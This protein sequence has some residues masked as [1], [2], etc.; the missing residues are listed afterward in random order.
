[1]KAEL[2][3][4]LPH[5]TAFNSGVV[6]TRGF[7]L[8]ELLISLAVVAIISV[9]AIPSYMEQ[10]KRAKRAEAKAFVLD[11]ASRQERFYTLYNSYTS[12]I[13]APSGCTGVACGLGLDSNLSESEHY[14]TSVS[15][16]PS[17]C[18]PNS[19][20]PC[21]AFTHTVSLVVTTSDSACTAF[22][23]TN[24]GVRG[25]AGTETTRTCWR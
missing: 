9:F 12:V 4:L 3:L 14:S 13:A 18:A 22:T 15:V 23:L 11:S 20:S 17:G 21:S 6:R 24:A 25:S 19:T 5:R 16:L 10:V 7:T 2:A 1:M 8:I